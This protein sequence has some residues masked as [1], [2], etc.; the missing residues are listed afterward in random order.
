[1]IL[2]LDTEFQEALSEAFR[3]EFGIGL[4]FTLLSSDDD[5][6]DEVRVRMKSYEVLDDTTLH[7]WVKAFEAGWRAREDK[8]RWDDPARDI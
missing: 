5:A 7:V 8:M 1:M 6:A 4:T 3:E 2:L